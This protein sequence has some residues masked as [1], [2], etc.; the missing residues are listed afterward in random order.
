MVCAFVFSPGLFLTRSQRLLCI[1]LKFCV[2]R[3]YGCLSIPLDFSICY[4]ELG[5]CFVS[6]SWYS[7]IIC[8]ND[9]NFLVNYLK[10]WLKVN[11]WS[12]GPHYLCVHLN[13]CCQDNTSIKVFRLSSVSHQL[14]FSKDIVK[15]KKRQATDEEIIF[16]KHTYVI[17]FHLP[18]TVSVSL[19]TTNLSFGT[20]FGDP[21]GN[22]RL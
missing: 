12:F 6:W 17:A 22:P 4:K 2:F 7:S 16:A 10:F 9:S 14:G 18:L 5:I 3:F 11:C 13:S 20:V 1:F 15:K 21:R 19:S 8:W